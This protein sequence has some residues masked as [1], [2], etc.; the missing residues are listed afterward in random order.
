MKPFGYI[1]HVYSERGLRSLEIK[2]LRS[3][4]SIDEIIDLYSTLI[5]RLCILYLKN[6]PDAEDAFQNTFV[7]LYTKAP[8][9]DDKE[10][11]KAWLI[12]VCQNECKGILRS[13][14]HRRV[15]SINDTLVTVTD[16]HDKDTLVCLMK[17]P[18]KYKTVLYLHYYEGYK[19]SE[20]SQILKLKES[21]IKTQLKRGRSLLKSELLNGGFEYE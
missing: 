19:I 15:D 3:T 8:L 9:F 16:E 20:L 6:I 1:N 14:W 13:F 10:H 12:T 7:K 4:Y 5:Y 17:L 18:L 2:T 11:I 21:T